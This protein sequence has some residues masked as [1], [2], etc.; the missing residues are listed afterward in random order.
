MM[1]NDVFDPF[2]FARKL[3]DKLVLL[4]KVFKAVENI[5]FLILG[6]RVGNLFSEKSSCHNNSLPKYN[7]DDL[8]SVNKVI[9]SRC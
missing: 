4:L 9:A 5:N 3:G 8:A 7:N 6:G 1:S 2:V